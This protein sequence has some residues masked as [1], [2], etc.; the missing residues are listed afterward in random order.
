MQI[1]NKQF[2]EAIK[3]FPNGRDKIIQDIQGRIT[4][5]AGLIIRQRRGI[6]EEEVFNP[7][8]D[9]ISEFVAG[10]VRAKVR[11]KKLKY[12]AENLMVSEGSTH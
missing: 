10:E 4:A 7:T 11:L 2:T 3:T 5:A 1:T 12:I 6:S 8:L 9:E